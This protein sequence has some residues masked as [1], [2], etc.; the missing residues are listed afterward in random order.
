MIISVHAELP[1]PDIAMTLG[2]WSS[3]ILEVG[4]KKQNKKTL[5]K[6]KDFFVF[7]PILLQSLVVKKMPYLA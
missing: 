1:F 3:T 5:E 2:L 7:T 6:K 4:N